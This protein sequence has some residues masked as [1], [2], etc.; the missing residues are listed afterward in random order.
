MDPGSGFLVAHFPRRAILLDDDGDAAALP[1]AVGAEDIKI[2]VHFPGAGGKAA[3]VAKPRYLRGVER[4]VERIGVYHVSQTHGTGIRGDHGSNGNVEPVSGAGYGHIDQLAVQ[5][6]QPAVDYDRIGDERAR[7]GAPVGIEAELEFVVAQF[8]RRRDVRFSIGYGDRARFLTIAQEHGLRDVRVY[9]AV[10]ARD[11]RAEGGFL[12]DRGKGRAHPLDRSEDAAYFGF[13]AAARLVGG[14]YAELR[15]RRNAASGLDPENARIGVVLIQ[16]VGIF[17]P[18]DM[19]NDGIERLC[20][21]QS[22]GEGAVVDLLGGLEDHGVRDGEHRIVVVRWVGPG[23]Q[24][25][26]EPGTVG[27]GDIQVNLHLVLVGAPDFEGNGIQPVALE[28]DERH[29]RGVVFPDARKGIRLVRGTPSV[30]YTGQ[31]G[32][33]RN[34]LFGDVA[35]GDGKGLDGGSGGGLGNGRMQPGTCP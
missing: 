4:V 2:Y 34:N 23:I 13:D 7:D 8:E 12:F 24:R 30:E 10:E 19:V 17:D 18:I 35:E 31:K 20:G 1:F 9:G 33:L 29:G 5:R 25:I 14:Y 15:A 3:Q 26:G 32:A 16:P 21:E 11:M 28:P 22:G 6:V 27:A